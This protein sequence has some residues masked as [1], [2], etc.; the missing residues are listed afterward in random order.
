M[1]EH[2]NERNSGTLN[3]GS[4]DNDINTLITLR[5]GEY[6]SIGYVRI[7][8]TSTAS[9]E[10]TLSLYDELDGTAPVDADRDIDNIFLSPGD[11]LVIDNPVY[12]TVERDVLVQVSGQD[13]EVNVTVGG[14][15]VTG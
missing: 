9:N 7:D 5:D 3:V 6:L 12:R 11:S 2:N 4:S 10:A 13:G 14:E 8:Y 15:S 1:S